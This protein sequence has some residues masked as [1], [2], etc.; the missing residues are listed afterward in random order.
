VDLFGG[1][2]KMDCLSRTFSS[3]SYRARTSAVI[4]LALGA[5]EVRISLRSPGRHGMNDI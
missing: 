2:G 4:A 5:E 1:H 3:R